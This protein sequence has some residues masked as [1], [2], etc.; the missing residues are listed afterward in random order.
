MTFNAD[1]HRSTLKLPNRLAR[2]GNGVYDS[3]LEMSV[4]DAGPEY[5]RGPRDQQPTMVFIHGFGGRAAYWEYQLEQ[6]QLDYRVIALD[7]RGHGY[8]DAPTAAEGASYDVPELVADIAAALD[9]LEVPQRFILVCH[10]FGG[11]LSAYFLKQFPQR[12]SALVMIASAAR[13]RL[14]LAGR[15][16]LRMPP[17]IFDMVRKL[18]PYA[19][20]TAA[21]I[22]PPSHVV[23]LQNRNA[24]LPWDGSEYLRAIAVP[25]L[26][27]LGHRDIL[28]DEAAYKEVARLIPGAEELVV[29]VSAHQVM[30]ERPDAVNR[31][32]QRFLQMQSDPSELAERRAR[33]KAERRA[34]RKQLEAE[35]PWL[36]FYDAR[37][38][39]RI[40]MPTVALPRLLE[41]TARRFGKTTALSYR[42]GKIDWRELDRQ[43]NRFAHGL[44][45]MRIKP[46]E[47][48][49]LA[50]P[51][52]PS[53]VIA[54]FGILKA[55]AVAVLSDAATPKEILLTRIA[56]AGAVMLVTTTDRYDELRDELQGDRRAAGLRRVIFASMIDHMGWREKL[57][58]AALHHVQEGHWLPWFRQDKQ[59]RR[60]ERRYLK[61]KQV[62]GRGSVAPTELTQDAGDIAVVVYTYGASG[63]PLPVALSH[64]N[65]A[66]NAL[67][68]RHWLPE[69]R[70]GDERFLAQ[71]SLASAYGLT[72]LLHLGVYL[73]AT[74]ILLPG[75]ELEPLLKTVKK[76]R[77]TYF[78]TTPRMVRE[79]A[80]TPGIRRY[81][82][83][84]IRVCAV[85]GSPL[86]Q[87][88]RE[89]FEKLTRGRL[90]EAYGLTEASPAVLAMPLAA[91]R[92]Q[93][94]VGIPLPDT[95]VKVVDL[96]T[97]AEL[98]SDTLGELWVRGPQLFSGYDHGPAGA[99]GQ[100]ASALNLIARKISKERLHD[101]W[102]AT[103]DVASIDEDGFVSI[104][105]RKSNMGIRGGQRVFPRQIEE[106]LFEHPAVAVAH[107][108]WSPD[109]EGVQHLRA[110]VLLHHNMKLGADDLLKYASKR[111]HASALPD[112][113]AVEQ[114]NTTVL[115]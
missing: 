26:V 27:I 86:A 36:K 51:N 73:G 87:E 92:I 42:G 93:G 53:L 102:L 96:D 14:R 59:H 94:V 74:L 54:Y 17:R 50:L 35:R 68:L 104:I 10:S 85:S 112:S 70:P 57:K 23:Y 25:T 20:I 13:F 40:K 7:L 21:R 115:F 18:M 62:L 58:F 11:A 64:R 80:H 101:G 3:A 105:D 69:S 76:M 32:I 61:F 30:V 12:V 66:S 90:V 15:I 33:Q 38:P 5:G 82:L 71:Q 39:Y 6:F 109:E 49:L 19:G 56:D 22:Y 41:A 2:N 67:Q 47:R 91:R 98:P 31:A 24:L 72:G 65:L 52:M 77:P 103:G 88:I 95:E 48:V 37:T 55:G 16:V 75:P 99:A 28:F 45:D 43:A 110:E 89:E 29:P 108:K 100:G 81:G 46:G 97:G 113:I 83:A 63:T 84:S 114:K 78:P 79:L 34:A 8:S 107:V 60:H 44:L 111:L 1:L 4:L 9:Q 106:V